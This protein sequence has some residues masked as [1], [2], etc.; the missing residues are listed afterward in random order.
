M[1]RA[2]ASEVYFEATARMRVT[3]GVVERVLKSLRGTKGRKSLVMVSAGFI[4]DTHIQEFKDVREAARRSNVAIYF[5]DTKG[6]EGMPNNFEAQFGPP[7]DTQDLGAMWIEGFEA[8]AGTEN[9]ALDTGGF[10]VRNTNNLAKGIARIA[11]ESQNYYLLGYYPSNTARDGKFREI[12]VEVGGKGLKVRARKGYYAPLDESLS[13]ERD[14]PEAED[15][16]FQL[17]LDS[18]FEIEDVPVR[19]THYVFD[20]KILGKA[21]AMLIAEVDVSEFGFEEKELEGKRRFV[22]TLEFFMVA[23]HRDSGEYLQYDEKINMKLL[24]RTRERFDDDWLPIVRDFEL[25][26]GGW[27]AKIVVRDANTGRIGSVVHEF[28]VPELTTLRTSSPIISDT[29]ARQRPGQEGPPRPKLLARRSFAPGAKLLCSY[30]VYGAQ[31]DE[32]TGMPL[33]LAG[34]EIRNE[35]GSTVA[36][37]A[38]TE[39]RATSLGGLSRMFGANLENIAPGRYDLVLTVIDQVADE[40]I[41]VTEPFW[42]EEPAPSS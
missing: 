18:P 1:L 13:V 12:D 38:P 30:D 37:T 14:E 36:E 11:A 9:L 29:I 42:L 6:L 22:D 3:L 26:P 16:E 24:P 20:E 40:T 41:E 32:A 25:L 8:A 23:A 2:R 34:W 27:Q 5:L 35:L 4:Y 21:S 15:P 7:I 17:A 39:I 10:I 19:M 28:D 33:V 31:R